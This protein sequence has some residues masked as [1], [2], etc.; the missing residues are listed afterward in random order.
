M[1]SLRHYIDIPAGRTEMRKIEPAA[2][3]VHKVGPG[4]FHHGR[5]VHRIGDETAGADV[6]TGI[7]KIGA[8]EIA[9]P[10]S[11]DVTVEIE[12]SLHAHLGT[13]G[14]R[15]RLATIGGADITAEGTAPNRA[16]VNVGTARIRPDGFVANPI[17]ERAERIQPEKLRGRNGGAKGREFR[18]EARPASRVRGWI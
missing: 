5:G 14:L 2:I 12:P 3:G 11:I 9:T 15:L 1:S 6:S 8:E 17:I 13:A 18:P 16:D 4:L 10:V 7:A